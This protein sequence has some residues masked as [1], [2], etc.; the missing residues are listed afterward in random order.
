MWHNVTQHRI[1]ARRPRSVPTTPLHQSRSTRHRSASRANRHRSC[2]ASPSQF[3]QRRKHRRTRGTTCL[4]RAQARRRSHTETR[5]RAAAVLPSAV[6]R[7]RTA[8]PPAKM[9]SE[10]SRMTP[11][12]VSTTAAATSSNVV[13]LRGLEPPLA[14][15]VAPTICLR[16]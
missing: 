7:G 13:C 4:F 2:R 15:G 14:P 3:P 8:A 10:D 5:R 16:K 12:P 1:V 11:A 6:R 9:A